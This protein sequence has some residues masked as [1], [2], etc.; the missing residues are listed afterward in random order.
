MDGLSEDHDVLFVLTTNRADLLEPALAS[1]PGRV[2]QAV[3]LALPD[4]SGRRRLIELYGEGLGLSLGPGEQLVEALEGT[5]PAFIRELLRRAA[6]V[7]AEESDDGPLRVSE[8]H[9]HAALAVRRGGDELTQTLLGARA[10][11][12][13]GEELEGLEDM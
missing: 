2:D 6:L 11:E 12:H 10:P 13:L 1:R 4:A 8:D 9:L 3:E 5:S 7:A